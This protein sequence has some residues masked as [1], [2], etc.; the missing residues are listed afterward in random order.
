MNGKT[1]DRY[2]Q[3]LD[4]VGASSV[5]PFVPVPYYVLTETCNALRNAAEGETDE[6][7][8]FDPKG[9][10]KHIETILTFFFGP[11]DAKALLVES[12]PSAAT[13]IFWKDDPQP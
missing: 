3:C 9:Q 4:K 2:K 8:A 13:N 11:M 12:P 7:N 5:G 1:W 10:L 6:L